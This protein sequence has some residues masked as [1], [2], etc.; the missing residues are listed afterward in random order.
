[1]TDEDSLAHKLLAPHAFAWFFSATLII[2][3]YITRFMPCAVA[4]ARPVFN[5]RN[6]MLSQG[7]IVYALFTLIHTV[8]L[9]DGE[10]TVLTNYMGG[11]L[12]LVAICMTSYVGN[13]FIVRYA[14]ECTKDDE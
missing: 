8:V 12:A 9:L 7:G 6:L 2:G 3:L 1:M 14:D 10:Q 13:C 5:L 4:G 11:L